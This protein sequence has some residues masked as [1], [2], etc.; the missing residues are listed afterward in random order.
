MQIINEINTAPYSIAVVLPNQIQFV[1]DL[2]MVVR[3]LTGLVV[4]YGAINQMEKSERKI[5]L[6]YALSEVENLG[7]SS[8]YM[9]MKVR[10]IK[11]KVR[12][13]NVLL[14]YYV[15]RDKKVVQDILKGFKNF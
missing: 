7:R 4:S 5:L 9:L 10:D 13:R 12:W 14:K 2:Q 6:D 3:L 8:T 1:D 15:N 11:E